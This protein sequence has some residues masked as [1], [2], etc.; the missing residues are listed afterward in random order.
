MLAGSKSVARMDAGIGGEHEPRTGGDVLRKVV[1]HLCLTLLLEWRQRTAAWRQQPE[2]R[3][4]ANSGDDLRRQRLLEERI[5][6]AHFRWI[7][8]A[9]HRPPVGFFLAQKGEQLL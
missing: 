1:R 2:L 9:H 8:E 3:R 5:G 7:G 4:G 6:V